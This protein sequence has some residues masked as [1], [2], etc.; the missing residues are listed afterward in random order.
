MKECWAASNLGLLFGI[1]LCH[2][3]LHPLGGWID[4]NGP[5]LDGN[6]PR[7]H[8]KAT[9]NRNIVKQRYWFPFFYFF[10][11]FTLQIW[12]SFLDHH[13]GYCFFHW[14][15]PTIAVLEIKW[16]A[17]VQENNTWY[18]HNGSDVAITICFLHLVIHDV[19]LCN[20]TYL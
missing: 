2:N 14:Q 15:L 18:S 3:V 20:F 6:T 9:H 17:N 7:S 19:S 1:N 8:Y 12:I 10:F 13:S 5:L 4:T 11:H 16:T